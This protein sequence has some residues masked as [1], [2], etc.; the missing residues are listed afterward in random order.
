MSNKKLLLTLG[1]GYICTHVSNVRRT[2]INENLKCYNNENEDL[3]IFI[4]NNN[5]YENLL[6]LNFNK[7]KNKVKIANFYMNKRE[8]SEFYNKNGEI[9]TIKL[10]NLENSLSINNYIKFD[11]RI[12]K[13]YVDKINGLNLRITA[14]EARLLKLEMNES[15]TYI[16]NGEKIIEYL[17][18]DYVGADKSK[19]L[20]RVLKI[21]LDNVFE[22]SKKDF[23]NTISE[24]MTNIE[25]SLSIKDLVSL[26]VY[27]LKL[28][29][30]DI[31]E[32]NFEVGEKLLVVQ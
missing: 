26:G 4:L 12:I 13:E 2:K 29:S 11:Y 31:E 6:M 16:F 25:T 3:S 5:T 1:A 32:Y 9:E 19:R 7:E 8:L 14:R 28:N 22:L 30:S 24:I 21:L 15:N 23:I 27:S 18:L 20:K 17:T 10:L